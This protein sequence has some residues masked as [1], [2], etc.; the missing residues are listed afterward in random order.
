MWIKEKK[1]EE[2]RRKLS[3]EIL[4][5]LCIGFII[6][7]FSF[8][9]LYLTSQSIA[10]TYL[11]NQGISFNV[12]Q[13]MILYEWLGNACFFA[14]VVVFIALFLFLFGQKISY[15][16]SIIKG[17]EAL[18]KSQMD[19]VLPVEGNDEFTQL[20]ETI[21]TLSEAQRE[22]RKKEEELRQEREDLIHSLSHDIRTPLTS[23]ISYSEY[24]RNKETLTREEMIQY[25]TLMQTKA[26]QIKVL[27]D[28]LMGKSSKNPERIENGKLLMEQLTMEWVEILEDQFLCEVDLASCDTFSGIFDVHDL[29]RIFDNLASNVE[30][31]ADSKKKVELK[32]ESRGEKL[33]VIQRNGIKA[34]H[35]LPVESHKIGIN[36]IR[37]IVQAYGGDIRILQVDSR[38]EIQICF[39]I[40]KSV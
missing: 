16:I 1:Q 28:Y 36:S 25:I 39:A 2:S 15:L 33:W 21:N 24:M 7:L 18:H 12:I 10:D 27:T 40:M 29:R 13:K 23:I 20:A 14:S 30:K 6:S 37:Q 31:Y 38:F 34:S 35:S 22:L 9:F 11:M 17:V 32:I 26:E 4:E 8:G 19:F 5:L 3:H